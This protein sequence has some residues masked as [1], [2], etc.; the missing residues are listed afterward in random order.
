MANQE[1]TV[2]MNMI[3]L[4]PSLR[5]AKRRS[6]LAKPSFYRDLSIVGL[7]GLLRRFASRNDGRRVNFVFFVFFTLLLGFFHSPVF[8]NDA[9][10]NV[11]VYSGIIP[12]DVIHQ[13]EKETGIKVNFSTYDSSETLYAKLRA[14]PYATYDVIEPS[15][16][17]VDRMRRQGMLEKLDK[18][19]LQA[20]NNINPDFLNQAYDPLNAYSVP[21]VWGTTGIFVNTDYY[22]KN[23]IKK[24]SDLWDPKYRD[25]L[26]LLNDA[27]EVFSVGLYAA[28][29]HGNDN[30]PL[31]IQ[32]AYSKLKQLIP[33]IKLFNSDAVISI[34]IDEDAVVGMAW[35]GDLFKA[36]QENPKL[37][38][39]YPDDGFV[40]WVDSL[41]IP[42]QA[43]HQKNAYQFINFLM[44]A[45]IAKKIALYNHYPTANLAA[46]RLLP[47]LMR[48]S[49]IVY[50]GHDVLKRGEFITDIS[51]RSLV[52]YE[53]YWE[54][55]KMGG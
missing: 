52:L 32:A 26:M 31:H 25:Q 53:K 43:P 54:L 2:M 36:K 22:P 44:R 50:P 30:N 19:R 45:D 24:W 23:S 37:E 4:R 1:K 14:T 33:N 40:I 29:F 18:S 41:S 42:R 3:T 55:L 13:F 35:N 10:L 28:G 27:R 48:K 7:T 47:D 6:N 17:Y 39:I 49:M 38:F 51:D 12:D 8:A 21:L 5:E 11:Y 9:I 34:F 15:S 20:M 46:Q 16:Y